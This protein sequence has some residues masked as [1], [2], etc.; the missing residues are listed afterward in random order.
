MQSLFVVALVLVYLAVLAPLIRR[1]DL[2]L[3][4]TRGMLLFIPDEMV[5]RVDAVKA[6][7]RQYAHEHV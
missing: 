3:K 2:T 6:L 1:M 5:Q 7:M 4:R